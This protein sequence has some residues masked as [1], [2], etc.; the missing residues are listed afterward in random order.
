MNERAVGPDA[1]ETAAARPLVLIVDDD[2]GIRGAVADIL[3]DEGFRTAQATDGADA[4]NFLADADGAPTVILL[5]L[6][7]PVLDGW[8]FCKIR[9]GI[10]SLMEI[11]VIAVSAGSMLGNREPLRVDATLGKPFDPD[12]LTWLTIRMAGR[13]IS[14][15]RRRGA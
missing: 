1:G 15:P 14:L 9:Q 7:M 6:M 13:R 3:E 12:E 8:A 11:P 5:D 2:Q 10:Q 4:L